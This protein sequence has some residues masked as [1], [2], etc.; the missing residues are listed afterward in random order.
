[1]YRLPTQLQE[2]PP[3]HVYRGPTSAELKEIDKKKREKARKLQG[4]KRQRAEK[5]HEE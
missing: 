4:V 3:I 5:E 2:I 1:M